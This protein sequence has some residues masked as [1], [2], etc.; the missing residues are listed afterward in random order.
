LLIE[1]YILVSEKLKISNVK[2][3]SMLR[4]W[5]CGEKILKECLLS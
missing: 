5:S 4:I 1:S 2:V 3:E